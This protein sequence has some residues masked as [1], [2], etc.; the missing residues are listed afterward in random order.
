VSTRARATRP[1]YVPSSGFLNLS[2][3]YSTGGFA[4]LL[5]PAATSRVCSVQGFLPP[6]SIGRL[7]TGRCPLAVVLLALTG[8]PAATLAFLGFEALLR[9]AMRFANFGD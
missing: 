7:V 6:R 3:V 9:V 2:T 1:R 4:G 8:C 5:H